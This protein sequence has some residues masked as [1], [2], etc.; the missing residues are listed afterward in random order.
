[1]LKIKGLMTFQFTEDSIELFCFVLITNPKYLIQETR[2]RFLLRKVQLLCSYYIEQLSCFLP[3]LFL[4]MWMRF[5][6]V[7]RASSWGDRPPAHC[8]GKYVVCGF[9]GHAQPRTTRFKL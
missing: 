9:D 3:S 4:M 1:M 7:D 6:A 2:E 8:T 5:S